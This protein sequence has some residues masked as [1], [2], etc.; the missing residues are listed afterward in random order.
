VSYCCGIGKNCAYV[1]RAKRTC[2]YSGIT[3][4]NFIG[5]FRDKKVY[6]KNVD[7]QQAVLQNSG[8]NPAEN[9]TI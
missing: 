8:S 7:V 1:G 9:D 4:V 3:E 2:K 6:T 5:D